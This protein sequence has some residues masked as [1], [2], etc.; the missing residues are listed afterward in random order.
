MHF[1][2]ADQ[3]VE[4]VDRIADKLGNVTVG[5]TQLQVS[6]LGFSELQ[7][8]LQQACQSVDVPGESRIKTLVTGCC[9]F[10]LINRS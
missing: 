3:R 4:S 7:Y 2:L 8:L 5:N 6:C 1:L 9:S 10:N